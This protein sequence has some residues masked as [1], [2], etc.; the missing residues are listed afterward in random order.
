MVIAMVVG[1]VAFAPIG[2][3]AKIALGQPA[4][5]HTS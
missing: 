3:L 5:T 4:W 1:M 2:W